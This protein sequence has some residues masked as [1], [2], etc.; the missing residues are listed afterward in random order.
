MH[1][2][3]DQI[4]HQAKTAPKANALTLI[5]P[6]E[7]ELSLNFESLVKNA[8]QR[9][10]GLKKLHV[11]KGEL[12]LL[13][14]DD[15]AELV[16]LFLGTIMIGA[17]PSILPLPVT[18]TNKGVYKH[19]RERIR[20]TNA[21]LFAT[22]EKMREILATFGQ[23]ESTQ[24]IAIA[25]IADSDINT[26]TALNIEA[27]LTDTAF[28]QFSSGTTGSAKGLMVSHYA[29]AN[30]VRRY[31]Q[32]IELKTSDKVVSW[33][34]LYHDQGL[35]SNLLMPLSQGVHTVLMAPSTWQRN[36]VVFFEAIDRYQCTISRWPNFAFLYTVKRVKEYQMRGIS[37]K[38][39]RL[40][41]SSGEPITPDAWPLFKQCFEA[42]GLRDGVMNGS[43]GMAE[44][45]LCVSVSPLN[46]PL[47]QESLSLSTLNTK[48]IAE[49]VPEGSEGSQ[50]FVSSGKAISGTEICILNEQGKPCI[51]RVIGEI[52]IK[53]D[54]MIDQYYPG[55]PIPEN[56]YSNGFYLT[57]DMGYLAEDWLTVTGRK[58]DVVIVGG[59]S[60]HPEQVERVAGPISQ[61]RA[62]R[63]IAFGLQDK[64]LGTEKL[65]A[66]CELHND[67]EPTRQQVRQQLQESVQQDLSTWLSRVFFR[68]KGWIEK[69][70]SGKLSRFRS[71]EK[72]LAEE[73]LS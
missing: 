67:D 38:S 69:T 4:I 20:S 66:V 49:V 7:E 23:L 30:Q 41:A 3:I 63:I 64:Q 25:D 56:N 31:A 24:V 11:D 13:L 26:D 46:E 22:S 27:D 6:A 72:L 50:I 60:I 71:K 54:C 9:A 40:I 33:S 61:I 12:V 59:N 43:F 48:S 58:K 29:L 70:T 16:P 19:L 62:G 5:G 18:G 36:P 1:T 37:L 21:K 51:D 17:L 44:N 8:R 28:V 47:K 2:V 34:P 52:A 39:L 55:V 53:G 35:V 10:I 32:A 65:I 14:S 45:C 42:F 68:E 57:G 73:G 15:L